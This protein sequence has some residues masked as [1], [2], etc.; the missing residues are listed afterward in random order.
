MVELA[1]TFKLYFLTFKTVIDIIITWS[2]VKLDSEC[3]MLSMAWVQDK[4][5]PKC[6]ACNKI[7]LT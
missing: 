3:S 5:S 6:N 2:D 7:F 4:Y 1:I